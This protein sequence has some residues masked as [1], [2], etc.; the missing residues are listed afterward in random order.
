MAD[1]DVYVTQGQEESS[2]NLFASDQSK[3]P[4]SPVPAAASHFQTLKQSF[5]FSVT[6]LSI[7]KSEF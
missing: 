7:Y 4:K 3:R 5:M 1:K 6:F 2:V